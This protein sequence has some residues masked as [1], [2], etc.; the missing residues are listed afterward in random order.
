[1]KVLRAARSITATIFSKD[2]LVLGPTVGVG[3]AVTVLVGVRVGVLV[4]MM[5]SEKVCVPE[6]PLPVAVTANVKVPVAVGVPATTPP[7]ERV[8][9]GGS[10][11]ETR[12]NVK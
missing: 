1:M 6:Q 12:V 3:L 11:P 7:A 10:A 4:A 8:S 9:P 2:R 5:V